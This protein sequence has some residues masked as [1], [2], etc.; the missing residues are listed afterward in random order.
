MH[1]LSEL[2]ELV[3]S[4]LNFKIF[5]SSYDTD[6]PTHHLLREILRRSYAPCIWPGENLGKSETGT[7]HMSFYLDIWE[8][9]GGGC[10]AT[11]SW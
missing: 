8:S 7:S 1:Q 2:I 5:L 4:K 6:L 9:Y 3:I 10:R 11:S